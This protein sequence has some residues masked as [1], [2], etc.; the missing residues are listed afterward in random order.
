MKICALVAGLFLIAGC[1]HD[2]H[3]SSPID[4]DGTWQGQM[5]GFMGSPPTTLI[6]NF[7]VDGETLTGT[8]NGGPGQWLPFENGKVKGDRISF[9]VHADWPG[10]MKM[11]WN[12]RGKVKGDEIKLTYKTR[13]SG[14]GG[15]GGMGDPPRMSLII[16]RAE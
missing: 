9:T 6:Y 15:F 1:A 11:R 10:G 5:A 2:A 16:R 3:L 13:T 7:K 4:I 8:V 12:Y 14:G